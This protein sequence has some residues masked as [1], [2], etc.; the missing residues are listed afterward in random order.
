MV[1]I[2]FLIFLTVVCFIFFQG[3]VP[4]PPKRQGFFLLTSSQASKV[5]SRLDIGLQG[6]EDWGQLNATL[7]STLRYLNRYPKRGFWVENLY[8][9]TSR[10][11]KTVEE[12]LKILPQLDGDPSLLVKR[13]N[14]YEL[15]PET[16]FTGY[17]EMDIQAS[18]SRDR[19]YKYPIYGLPSD[20]KRAYLGAFHP[21]WKGQYLIYRI[22]GDHI[23]PYYSRREIDGEGAILHKAPIIAWAKDPVDV[24]FL[25][26]QGSGRLILPDGTYKYIGYAGKNGRQYISI[27]RYLLK[28]GYISR[29]NATLDGIM[30]FLK[31]HPKLVPQVLYRNPSY[32]FFRL[33]KDGPYGAM[34]VK[35][36]P[37]LSLAT[38]PRVL[39]LGSLLVF[40]VEV[41]VRGGRGYPLTGFGISQDVG[42]AITGNHVDL[43]FGQGEDARFMA[44]H[45]SNYGKIYLILAKEK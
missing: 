18:L 37:L 22:E 7:S 45:M 39:P 34:G 19:V 8:I 20:L 32:V 17:F 5:L 31:K 36:T 41:P 4:H 10:L 11:K 21:R 23:R 43:F 3:C 42:G 29:G 44:G 30:A 9:S 38:D 2:K 15:V 12:M 28:K 16:L 24:F 27:G 25:Q 33:L 26:I 40:N 13:F 1:R 35:L 6:I 14:W